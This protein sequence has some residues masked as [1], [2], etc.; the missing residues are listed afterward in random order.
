MTSIFVILPD[1]LFAEDLENVLS[2]AKVFIM[3]D[4]HF[5]NSKFHVQKLLLHRASMRFYFD[6][7]KSLAKGKSEIIYVD[8]KAFEKVKAAS[9]I[10]YLQVMKPAARVNM[11]C[12][13][14]EHEY[15][16]ALSAA[17]FFGLP[18][19]QYDTPGFLLSR[20]D[21]AKFAKGKKY[22]QTAFY[23][24]MRR[25]W[26]DG[27]LN[28]GD[29]PL[30]G[31]WV[32]DEQ[33]RDTAASFSKY[34]EGNSLIADKIQPPRLNMKNSYFVEAAAYITKIFKGKVTENSMRWPITHV[35]A[36][37]WL[38]D[39]ISKRLVNFGRFQDVS[40]IS[41]EG[42]HPLYHSCLS[43]SINI[44]LLTPRRI[45]EVASSAFEKYYKN[46]T[47]AA[48]KSRYLASVEGFIRQII[49]WREF[50]HLNYIINYK[51]LT[52]GLDQPVIPNSA[53]NKVD[54]S[55]YGKNPS[56]QI[57]T[58]EIYKVIIAPLLQELFATGYIHHIPRLMILSNYLFLKNV[59]PREAY[60]WFLSMFID[61]YPWVMLPN[62]DMS[63][64]TCGLVGTR[65]YFSSANYLKKM[66][67]FADSAAHSAAWI[68]EWNA[69]YYNVINSKG[70]YLTKIYGF[71]P[72]LNYWKSL[73]PAE[74][75]ALLRI[76]D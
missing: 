6:L 19:N 71:A 54:E 36:N 12:P 68:K 52:S 17:K 2:C 74:R 14:S 21:A 59:S 34:L 72:I 4:P 38:N 5:F 40:F 50:I 13:S 66:I 62:I 31:K 61:A 63:M 69:L 42:F 41:A 26:T 29:K 53:M 28:T 67:L 37:Q 27:F 65:P 51:E 58:E 30:G 44:G 43:S 57:K 3:E 46:I 75:Q 76:K 1:Q 22:N 45:L 9:F 10:E 47:S 39:F 56:A 48:D 49:G 64:Y 18:I 60:N 32:Y 33:N 73:K 35:E 23:K 20:S 55:W 24:N 16:P 8:I 15:E 11:W 7:L 25:R 70:R